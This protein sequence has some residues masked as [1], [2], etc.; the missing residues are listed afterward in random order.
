MRFNLTQPSSHHRILDRLFSGLPILLL[1]FSALEVAEAAP[2]PAPTEGRLGTGVLSLIAQSG[3]VAKIILLILLFSS[4]ASWTLAFS[5]WFSLRRALRENRGFLDIFWAGKSIDDIFSQ[6]DRFTASP[7]ALVFKAGVKELRK[8]VPQ[9]LNLENVYRA[10]SRSAQAEV[11]HLE[12]NI[13]WLATIASAAPFVGLF[14][15]VWGI[16]NSFQGIGASGSVNLAVVAP[17]ISEAL[18]TTAMGIGAA[19]PAVIAYNHF[20]GQ[21]KKVAVDIECFSQDFL[22]IVQR[23]LPK[24]S[25]RERG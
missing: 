18:I 24:H 19:I 13:S 6:S 22:N 16:M 15:T 7:V 8:V 3:T 21:I 1:V 17:G 23:N 10:L 20:A 2:P 4:V 9:E 14:G 25:D 5:K 11:T 12:K